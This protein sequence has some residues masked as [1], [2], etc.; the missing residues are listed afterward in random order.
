MEGH[1]NG[2]EYRV[3]GQMSWL[4]WLAFLLLVLVVC[5]FV[6]WLGW[7]SM[8][9]KGQLVSDQDDATTVTGAFPD[10]RAVAH[11]FDP[12]FFQYNLL[13]LLLAVLVVPCVTLS[14][15]RTMLGRKERRLYSE[16]PQQH[17]A[18]VRQLLAS[19]VSFRA[20]LGSVVLTTAVVML[21]ASIILVF[22]PVPSGGWGGVDFS[23]GANVLMMGPFIK[24]YISDFEQ[25]YARL[26]QSLTAFQFGFL[27]AYIYFL[28][29]VAR[30]YFTLDLTP[31]TFVDGTIRMMAASL[32]A[33]V[34][35]FVPL[36]GPLGL[37][38]AIPSQADSSSTGAQD[39]PHRA[40]E[41]PDAK[42]PQEGVSPGINDPSRVAKSGKG[43]E[44][45]KKDEPWNLSLLPVFSFF[46]GF[47]PKRARLYLERVTIAAM[48]GMNADHYRALPLS[49][50]AGMSYSHELRLEREG[51]DNIENFGT[52]NAVSLAVR[53][54]F[55]YPQLVQWISE[56]WLA[57][58]LREDYAAFVARTG[59]TSRAEL[60]LYLSQWDAA[61][62]DAMAHLAAGIPDETARKA[63]TVKL[64][65]L[66]TLLKA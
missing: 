13:M 58:H 52:A 21:G 56:A 1:H 25:Y 64:T 24:L 61:R 37:S 53:T 5:G 26:T 63:Q 18:E 17:R 35:S 54:G 29:S 55:R 43:R 27:G 16:V 50:L 8:Q 12:V 48:K 51:F 34:L 62:G 38:V 40:S 22:K 36:Y 30:A 14:Y 2:A 9:L 3:A 49:M 59:I 6:A 19:R 42:A 60:E 57:I 7:E 23:R 39:R 4:D 41:S 66:A 20:Y 65:T 32:L 33:L 44:Q 11:W 10:F 31:Q 47:Y 46:F 45:V 28:G 15:L